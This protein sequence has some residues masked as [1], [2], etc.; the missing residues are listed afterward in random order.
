MAQVKTL[1]IDG[2]YVAD[3]IVE[4]GTET[5]TCTGDQYSSSGRITTGTGTTTWFWEK[6][7]SGIAKCWGEFTIHD[8][9]TANQYNAL[10]A[11]LPSGLFKSRLMGICSMS[12]WT[13]DSTYDN[14]RDNP[15]TEFQLVYWA[16]RASTATRKF[17]VYMFGKWK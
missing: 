11:P 6:W 10:K 17:T 9:V 12:D 15:L 14:S 5:V 16:A 4:Q 8:T 1:N 2:S 7:N 13:I 3:F